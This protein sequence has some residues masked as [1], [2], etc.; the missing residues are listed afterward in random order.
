[1]MLAKFHDWFLGE[2]DVDGKNRFVR[3][4]APSSAGRLPQL[5][6]LRGIAILLVVF[7]HAW[8]GVGDRRVAILPTASG[9]GLFGVH[10]FFVL[11]GFLITSLLLREFELN[12]RIL[13]GAFYLRRARRLLPALLLILT[14]YGV[15][16]VRDAGGVGDIVV[17]IA[18]IANLGPLINWIPQN[19]GLSH[20]WSLAVEEQF[21]LAW[22]VLVILAARR[23]RQSVTALAAFGIVSTVLLRH[24]LGTATL[25]L[26][27]DALMLGCLL[28]VRPVRLPPLAGWVA[29]GI[30]GV[31]TFYVPSVDGVWMVTLSSAVGAVALVGALQMRWVTA[32]PLRYLGR[33]SYGLYLWHVLLLFLN[34]PVALALILSLGVA[35]LSYRLVERRFIR[36]RALP[37]AGASESA[38]QH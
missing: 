12:G 25:L 22:P 18:Y 7:A 30:L 9:G 2:P 32:A 23:S 35:E 28:A 37:D 33:I 26:R 20:T 6:G 10:L 21:Y 4:C 19:G 34:L 16:Y 14:F 5:D 13:L 3:S 15:F 29:F 1:M 17:A 8:N 38:A 31:T 11:S 24:G 27:W 36:H